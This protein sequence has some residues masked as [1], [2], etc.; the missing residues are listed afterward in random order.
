MG[1]VDRD[2]WTVLQRGGDLP[3]LAAFT[4]PA[5]AWHADAAC[6]GHRTALWF[7]ERGEPAAPA[8]QVC[9]AC[10]VAL[11]CL[12]AAFTSD[13]AGTWG[14]VVERRRL[15]VRRARQRRLRQRAAANRGKP[16]EGCSDSE[17]DAGAAPGGTGV[18]PCTG[19]AV[20]AEYVSVTGRQRAQERPP[21]GPVVQSTTGRARSAPRATQAA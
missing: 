11:D 4:G 3:D 14:G 7:P 15:D 10:P 13:E 17:L 6:R 19:L 20:R 12:L 21:T 2:A 9:R 5:P 1:A 8:R 18:A 16:G